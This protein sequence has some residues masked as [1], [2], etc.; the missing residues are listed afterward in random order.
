MPEREKEDRGHSHKIGKS[1][2]LKRHCRWAVLNWRWKRRFKWVS[3][4]VPLYS[5]CW[6]DGFIIMWAHW[7]QVPIPSLLQVFLV[8][9]ILGL[10]MPP[11]PLLFLWLNRIPPSYH[12]YGGCLASPF[13]FFPF[14]LCPFT[15]DF[16]GCAL[17]RQEEEKSHWPLII[18]TKAFSPKDNCPCW[19]KYWLWPS[20]HFLA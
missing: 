2:Q 9:C 12:H 20:N 10:C 14:F 8:S 7:S 17:L 18:V 1:F 16:A 11:L 6:D 13:G 3:E 15:T 5:T 4:G 19:L